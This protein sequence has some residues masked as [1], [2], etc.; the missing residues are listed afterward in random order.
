MLMHDYASKSFVKAEDV[1]DVPIRGSTVKSVSL[2]DFGRPVL[3]FEDGRRLSLNKSNVSIMMRAFGDDSRDWP[4]CKVDLEFGHVKYNGTLQDS[5][6]VR[7]L[8]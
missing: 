1:K 4:G 3:E 5:V 2:G 6:I 7:P 8:D